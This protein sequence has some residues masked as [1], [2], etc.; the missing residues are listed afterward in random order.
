MIRD[1]AG[2]LAATFAVIALAFSGCGATGDQDQPRDE[3]QVGLASDK[4]WIGDPIE[5][6]T[7]QAGGK[8][9]VSLQQD[10]RRNPYRAQRCYSYE[11]PE[12]VDLEA[13]CDL[14]PKYGP[15]ERCLI[16]EPRPSG[17][18]DRSECRSHRDQGEWVNRCLADHSYYLCRQFAARG[19]GIC[20]TLPQPDPSN[21]KYAMRCY[22]TGLSNSSKVR[23]QLRPN[24]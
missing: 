14:D 16:T 3:P 2:A 15:T 12:N 10:D 8:G 20:E 13:I 18:F 22:G 5:I 23:N 11:N 21:Y 7:S 17:R 24:L 9:L 19:D 4:P 6:E 1:R